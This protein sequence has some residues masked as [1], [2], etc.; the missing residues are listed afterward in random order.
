MFRNV[1]PDTFIFGFDTQRNPDV[2]QLQDAIADKE[3]M[4]TDWANLNNT[5][6]QMMDHKSGYEDERKFSSLWADWKE[7]LLAICKARKTTINPLI[8]D[9]V[10]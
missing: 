10:A 8:C 3:G 1:K 2:D 9:R 5:S 4:G 6:I 7:P